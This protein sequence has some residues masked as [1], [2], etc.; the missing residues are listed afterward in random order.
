MSD[1]PIYYRDFQDTENISSEERKIK[2]FKNTVETLNNRIN[3]NSHYAT[4][5]R[6]KYKDF[7][8]D[9]SSNDENR[10]FLTSFR[11]ELTGAAQANKFIL[12]IAYDPFEYGQEPNASVSKIEEYFC[13]LDNKLYFK[14]SNA[15][16]FIIFFLQYTSSSN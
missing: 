15:L 5:F 2:V 6:F 8:I 9:T 11:H 7:E 4:W 12:N 13:K 10:Q 14:V 16:F 3:T 1:Y